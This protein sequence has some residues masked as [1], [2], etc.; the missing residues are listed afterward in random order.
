MPI[1]IFAAAAA[2]IAAFEGA[3]ILSLFKQLK[4]IRQN[5]DFIRENKTNMKLTSDTPFRSANDLIDSINSM[6]DTSDRTLAAYSSESRSLKDSLTGISHDIRTPLTSLGGY[7]R[8]LEASSDESERQKYYG[9]ID[10]RINDLNIMLEQLF[11]YTKLQNNSFD[12]ETCRVDLTACVIDT[13][14]AFYARFNELGISPRISVDEAPVYICGN[15][16]ALHRIFQNILKNA[17]EHG[18]G[19]ISVSFSAENGKALFNCSNKCKTPENID[20]SGVFTKFYKADP[21][22]SD[23]ST[24]LGLT[25]AKELA[26]R[27]G[28]SIGAELTG[29]DF[30]VWVSFNTEA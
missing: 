30:S 7:F 24:G 8:L 29:D 12:I 20:I 2:V 15:E 22:R 27:L 4:T 23:T 10:A 21:A 6:L 14:L 11:T 13:V 3:V 25:I 5:L 26:E 9:I 16:D 1:F 19:E 17:A 18:C 28:G